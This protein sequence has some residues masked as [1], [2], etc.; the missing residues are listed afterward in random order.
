[1]FGGVAPGNL[2]EHLDARGVCAR[3]EG[4]IEQGT[5]FFGQIVEGVVANLLDSDWKGV[6]LLKSPKERP[7]G[8]A[9]RIGN[10]GGGFSKKGGVRPAAIRGNHQFAVFH[11]SAMHGSSKERN[12]HEVVLFGPNDQV[13]QNMIGMFDKLFK[14]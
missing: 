4:E 3:P 12:Q 13:G 2:A 6:H 11:P 14:P 7:V 10:E 5:E 1:V 8:F 9:I